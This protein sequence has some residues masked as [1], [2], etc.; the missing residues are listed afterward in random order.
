MCLAGQSAS[1]VRTANEAAFIMSGASV[2]AVVGLCAL[3]DSR[4]LLYAPLMKRHLKDSRGVAWVAPLITDEVFAT[5]MAK[6][7]SVENQK[8]WLVGL[9][10][11]AWTAWWGGTVLGVYGGK[12]LSEYPTMAAVMNFAF[13]AL[14]VSLSTHA[15]KKEPKFRPALVAAAVVALAC[16]YFGYG[17]FAILVAGGVG[18]MVQVLYARFF[19]EKQVKDV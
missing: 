2:L 7:E 1:F 8:P 3:L 12:L 13:V 17:E 18:V 15:F 4:H 10:L 14:F 19:I 16:A 6:L 11:V 9:A 5:S